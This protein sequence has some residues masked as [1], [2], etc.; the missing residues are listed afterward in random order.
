MTY[1]DLAESI[2]RESDQPLAANEIW[3]LAVKKGLDNKLD[4]KGKTPWATLAARLY[5][6]VKDNP[7]SRFKTIGQRPKRF[8]LQNKTYPNLEMFATGEID[9]K[10]RNVSQNT[11]D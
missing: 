11:V 1:H 8:Y 4:G 3:D 10:E 2:L 5:V 6:I 9:D 7:N